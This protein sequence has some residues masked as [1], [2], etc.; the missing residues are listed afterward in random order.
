MKSSFLHRPFARNKRNCLGR[1]MA[2]KGISIISAHHHYALPSHT[3]A[4]LL[5]PNRC[6]PFFW[7]FI[8][9]AENPLRSPVDAASPLFAKRFLPPNPNFSSFFCRLFGCPRPRS[10]PRDVFLADRSAL[11]AL[12][13]SS[14]ATSKRSSSLAA[15]T[16]VFF[17][18]IPSQYS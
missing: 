5:F 15:V 9:F 12:L 10:P 8:F 11:S 18:S 14:R 17:R 4:L 2:Q 16:S 7:P 6:G 13:A 1:K 3:F